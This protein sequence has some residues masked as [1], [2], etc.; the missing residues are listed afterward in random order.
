MA[1]S[2]SAATRRTV[3]VSVVI[4]VIL[5]VLL[6]GLAVI[7]WLVRRPANVDAGGTKDR[8][9]LFSIYGFEGDLLRRPTGVGIDSK[10]NIYV[11]DTGKRRIVVFNSS[12]AFL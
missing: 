11:A 2:N 1:S 12:G 3:V 5:A 7:N 8:N 6:A 4:L 10:G 9:Y